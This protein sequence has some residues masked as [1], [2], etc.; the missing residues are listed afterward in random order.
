MLV[1]AGQH[2]VV[3]LTNNFSRISVPVEELAFLGWGDGATPQHLRD[4][5]DD[6]C[7]SSTLGKRSELC[8]A[9]NSFVS[10][11]PHR[12]PEAEFY[13]LACSRNGIIPEEAVFLDDIGMYGWRPHL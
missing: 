12:K 9:C 11:K 5:F 4:L 2:K 1:A 10:L 3:A 7:D 8:E 6:F 13:L